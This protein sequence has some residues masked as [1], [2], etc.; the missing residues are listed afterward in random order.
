MGGFILSMISSWFTFY[1]HFFNNASYGDILGLFFVNCLAS[2][3]FA[4]FCCSFFDTA[5]TASQIVLLFLIGVGACLQG[6]G[7]RSLFANAALA[8]LLPPLFRW[9]ATICQSG[10]RFW[11]PR[12]S[13]GDRDPLLRYL[14]L[15]GLNL[16][17]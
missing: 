2:V 9:A 17:L 12:H 3:P 5:Q 4:L 13:N 6:I 10:D 16:V 15:H 1:P 14:S 7:N 8:R 11:P